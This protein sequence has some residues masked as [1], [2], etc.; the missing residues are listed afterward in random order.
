[1]KI[2]SKSKI[3]VAVGVLTGLL[4]GFVFGLAFGNPNKAPG[5][6]GKV[7]GNVSELA[8]YRYKDAGTV[9]TDNDEINKNADT[10]KL[11]AIDREGKT[12]NIVVTK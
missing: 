10:L 9:L 1:M 6:E 2:F 7:K 12:W 5:T 4:V 3:N 11:T 8:R